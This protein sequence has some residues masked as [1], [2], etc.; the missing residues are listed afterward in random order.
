MYKDVYIMSLYNE[1]EETNK[2]ILEA[3]KFAANKIQH[4]KT[5]EGAEHL[6]KSVEALSNAF[7]NLCTTL[8][9]RHPDSY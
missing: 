9:Y 6:A 3:M 5:A 4:M 8:D 2:A 7:K 1:R